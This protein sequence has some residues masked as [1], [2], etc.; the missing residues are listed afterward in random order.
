MAGDQ[1]APS[2]VP[3]RRSSLAGLARRF[4][5][6]ASL[7]PCGSARRPV[8]LRPRLSTGLPFYSQ[9]ESSSAVRGRAAAGRIRARG[10]PLSGARVGVVLGVGGTTE[11]EEVQQIQ[12]ASQE[13]GAAPGHHLQFFESHHFFAITGGLSGRGGPGNRPTIGLPNF[14]SMA[15]RCVDS[16]R[17]G[18]PPPHDAPAAAHPEWPRGAR[19]R[20]GHGGRHGAPTRVPRRDSALC[21]HGSGRGERSSWG[22]LSARKKSRTSLMMASG[23]SQAP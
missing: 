15:V 12:A 9:L 2:R 13:W 19:S 18:E 5:I 10:L 22:Q 17:V 7:E 21:S 8:A 20:G 6:R 4:T 1:V 3:A 16:R 11:R 23:S 14:G